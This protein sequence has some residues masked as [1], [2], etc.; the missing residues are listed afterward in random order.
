MR[1]CHHGCPFGH[2]YYSPRMARLLLVLVLA[3]AALAVTGASGEESGSFPLDRRGAPLP[4]RVSSQLASV[5]VAGRTTLDAGVQRIADAALDDGLTEARSAGLFPSG[6][7]VVVLGLEERALLAAA[8]A[9]EPTASRVLEALP[10]GSVLKPFV[11]IAAL[12]EGVDPRERR[13]CP[14][15]FTAGGS[16]IRNWRKRDGPALTIPEAIAQSCNTVFVSLAARLWDAGD[17]AR[18]AIESTF[19]RFGFGIPTG[20]VPGEAPGRVPVRSASLGDLMVLAIGQGPLEVTPLQVALSYAAVAGEPR[21][22]WLDVTGHEVPRRIAP[23]EKRFLDPVREGL[24]LAV[25]D[26]TARASFS[27]IA[28]DRLPIAGK[29]GSAEIGDAT[30][31]GWFAAY[32]P[33]N[34][35][36][37]VIVVVVERGRA[38]AISAAP[39]A[40]RILD[41]ILVLPRTP[42]PFPYPH[43]AAALLLLPLLAALASAAAGS[44]VGL[45]SGVAA[46]AI[47]GGSVAGNALAFS[48]AGWTAGMLH[49]RRTP[50]AAL[51]VA[52]AVGTIALP[53]DGR[54]VWWILAR[55]A[56][57]GAATIPAVEVVRRM[58]SKSAS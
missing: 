34:R 6:G 27:D 19:V 25:S 52:A 22:G 46:G 51:G 53:A 37:Y 38:G 29:T 58:S 24:E 35:P 36:R 16:T 49:F 4:P 21:A 57:A 7:A 54:G 55:A 43:P 47:T 18:S 15:R 44:V 40:R 26:G 56:F 42:A 33:A 20:L 5:G 14:A 32:A 10:A 23:P 31:Y 9:P 11:A 48:V 12:G 8:S 2:R 39:I 3:V 28:L 41:R 17:R 30:P 1:G 50:P 45:A 13:P